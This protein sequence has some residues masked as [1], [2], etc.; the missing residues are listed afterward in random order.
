MNTNDLRPA[1]IPR[2]AGHHIDCIGTTNADRDHPKAASIW[3]M[4]I[5]PDH[6]PTRECVVLKHH[7]VDN[8]RSGTP[9]A[10]SVLGRN[11]PEEVV[12]LAVRV[13]CHSEVNRGANLRLDEVVTVNC[14]WDC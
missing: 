3:R 7:L 13:D 14:R 10:D 4:R 5:G 1:N 2:E 12:N 6:H 8:S 9:E 11:A